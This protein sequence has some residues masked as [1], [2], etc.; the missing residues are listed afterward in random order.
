M[1][2]PIVRAVF[3]TVW[4]APTSVNVGGTQLL[5]MDPARPIQFVQPQGAVVERHGLE[6]DA[7]RAVKA[8]AVPPLAVFLPAMG[9]DVETLKMLWAANTSDGLNIV[10]DGP[11]IVKA[12]HPH[13]EFGVAFRPFDAADAFWYFP[14]LMPHTDLQALMNRHPWIHQLAE[15]NLVMMAGRPDNSNAPAVGYGSVAT[16]DALYGLGGG[17]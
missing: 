16:L 5:G 17:A 2:T 12:G 9:G 4:T 7:V 13:R 1:A 11:T 15:S 10:T 6:A 3:A 8:H 14:R